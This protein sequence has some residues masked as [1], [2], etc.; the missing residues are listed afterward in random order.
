MNW[1]EL[2][3]LRSVCKTW[4]ETIESNPKVNF[5]FGIITFRS[6]IEP[7]MA[8]YNASSVTWTKFRFGGPFIFDMKRS[9]QNEFWNKHGPLMTHLEINNRA[10]SLTGLVEILARCPKLQFFKCNWTP[11]MYSFNSELIKKYYGIHFNNGTFANLQHLSIQCSSSLT[12]SALGSILKWC[13]GSI[14]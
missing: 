9:I 13:G 14:R 6:S 1:N 7:K 10:M 2:L 12:D 3:P 11:E 5:N 4:F 8:I